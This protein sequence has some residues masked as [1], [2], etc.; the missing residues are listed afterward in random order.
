MWL[1]RQVRNYPRLKEVS[2]TRHGQFPTEGGKTESNL[3]KQ[4]AFAAAQSLPN[5]L[6]SQSVAFHRRSSA[7]RLISYLSKFLS[8]NTLDQA[9]HPLPLRSPRP[10]SYEER[11]QTQNAPWTRHA[12][13]MSP[14]GMY[15]M[16]MSPQ[17][18]KLDP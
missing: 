4:I 6:V 2:L 16:V 5:H 13:P 11:S 17:G 14:R 7:R 18:R 8:P 9:D 1:A 15:V 10:M 12:M 3:A